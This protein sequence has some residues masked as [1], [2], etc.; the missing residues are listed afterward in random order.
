MIE[1]LNYTPSSRISGGHYC[2]G[3]FCPQNYGGGVYGNVSIST[4]FSWSYNTS[5]LRL[6]NQVGV[7]QAF[8]Y[9]D[10]FHFQSIVESDR[11]YPA[12]IG[13]LTYGVTSLEMA[14]A[15]TSFIDGSYMQ[16]HAIRQVTDLQGN[17]LYEWPIKRDVIWSAKTVGH[18]RSLLTDVV[19]KGTGKGLYTNTSYIGAKTGTTNDY[20]DFWV[21][22]LTENYTTAIWIGYDEPRNMQSLENAKIHFKLF[23]A[24]MD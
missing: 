15:Y 20:K 19:T 6:L 8:S 10:R 21:A 5:A 9:I 3:D 23:N 11:N 16:A 18:M 2:V 17:V 12:A 7:E 24:I 14:D 4:A 1:L 13:G 22:G